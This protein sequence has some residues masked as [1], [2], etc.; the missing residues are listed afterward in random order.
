M[1]RPTSADSR[2]RFAAAL[3]LA[4]A[5]CQQV[6]LA[7]IDAAANRDRI[8]ARSLTDPA[9]DDALSRHSLPAAPGAWSLDQL[10]L[11]AWTLRTDVAVARA[12]VGAARAKTGVDAQRPNPTVATTT[13]KVISG[14][15]DPWVLGAALAMTF[16]LGGKRDIRRET[17]LAGERA[18]EWAFGEALWS[19]RAE[20]RSAL[21]DLAFASE[22]VALDGDEARLAGDYLAWVDTRL[23]YGAATTSERLAAVQAL[24]ESTSRREL[25]GVELARTSATLAAAIG[26]TPAE[27][28]RVQPQLPPLRG[29]PALG[30]ADVSSARDLALVNRLDVRRA[31]EE[32]A[33][34]EQGL[35]AAVATQYPDLTLAP[36]YLLDQADHKITLG[37]DLPVPLFHNANAAIKRAVA[38]RAVA[39]A[40][41]DD[42]QAAALAAIDVAIAEYR[43]ARAALAAVEQGERD[44]ADGVTSL[45]RRLD[46]GAANRG[47]LLAGEIAL[48]A[49]R[50]STLAARRA[51]LD[52]VSALEQGV[53][54]PLYPVS[55]IDTG[56][57][58]LRE[59][60]V[61]EP[62]R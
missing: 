45:E 39:A 17:A 62:A 61:G 6:P 56:G 33:V 4:C 35:R 20:V 60:L 49:L 3:L 19:A 57:G 30:D 11:A 59:L 41:F 5:G 22:S 50:R 29:V 9:V 44:A 16:E 10:T 43:A 25:D 13:E 31:L 23:Q 52:A 51:L 47:Q 34:A 8:A 27:L 32:Y 42:T 28:A 54:R 58:A 18:A 55:A 40:K 48:A 21:L 2:L 15:P 24:N 1:F 37:L 36:G 38:E 14:G 7:P 26:V 46:A 12:E 53:E